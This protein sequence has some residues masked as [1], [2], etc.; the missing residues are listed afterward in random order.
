MTFVSNYI[1]TEQEHSSAIPL[2]QLQEPHTLISRCMA[3]ERAAQ[4][5]FYKKYYGKLMALCMRYLKNEDDAMDA[6]N[7]GFLKIFRNL[8]KYQSQGSFEGWMYHIMRNTILDFIRS[9]VKY[10]DMANIE[11]IEYEFSIPA[12][13]VQELYA[14]DLLKLL[15][16]LPEST[17]TVFNLFAIE[18]CKHEEIAKLLGISEG[19]SKWHVAEARKRL[20]KRIKNWGVKP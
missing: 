15:D 1:V 17:R 5:E 19:T 4:E 10:R 12:S 9:Q 6:L 13:A 20:Q 14:K 18:G 16:E 3:N 11:T 7:T 2:N 8:D